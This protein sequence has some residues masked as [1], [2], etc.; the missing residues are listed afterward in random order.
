[1]VLV[2]LHILSPIYL[3][4]I[5]N[6]DIMTTEFYFRIIFYAIKNI[7]EETFLMM[8]HYCL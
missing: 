4:P 3:N 7:E 2:H 6:W 8:F 1:M 5:F